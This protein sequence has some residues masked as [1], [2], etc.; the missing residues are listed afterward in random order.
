VMMGLSGNASDPNF[1]KGYLT[2]PSYTPQNNNRLSQ[3]MNV[4][5]QRVGVR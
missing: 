2:S 4:L 5:N 3:M 1:N